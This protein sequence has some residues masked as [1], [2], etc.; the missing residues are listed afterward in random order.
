MCLVKQR[1]ELCGCFIVELLFNSHLHRHSESSRH[2]NFPS[3]FVC[4]LKCATKFT[5][6]FHF[7]STRKTYLRGFAWRWRNLLCESF[8]KS[9]RKLTRDLHFVFQSYFH[10]VFPR[11]LRVLRGEKSLR[12]CFQFHLE[13]YCWIHFWDLSIFLWLT[14]KINVYSLGRG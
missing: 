14:E 12:K 2:N 3:L 4:R 6:Q 10:C 9:D 13:K 8:R 7:L 11:T 5:N 1:D